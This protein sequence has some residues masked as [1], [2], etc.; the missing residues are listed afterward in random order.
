MCQV[1]RTLDRLSAVIRGPEVPPGA[2][3]LILQRLRAWIGEAQD[4]GELARGVAPNPLQLR[5]APAE[6][7]TPDEVGEGEP[8]TPG[9]TAKAP[10]PLPPPSPVPEESG[11]PEHRAAEGV[12]PV[13]REAEGSPGGRG[14]ASSSKPAKEE[15]KKRKAKRRSPS[16]HRGRRKEA[17][18]SRSGRSRPRS[19]RSRLASPVRPE[20][21]YR[22]DSEE[23]TARR[24]RK[25]RP[26]SPR[27]PSRPPVRRGPAVQRPLGRSD[28]CKEVGTSSWTRSPFSK[29]QRS[30]KAEAA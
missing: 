29:E 17:R 7:G 21:V 24:E 11:V 5:R 9:V 18:R 8:P 10:P 15:K 19:H 22:S 12:E 13:K 6:G 25:S 1:C 14:T 20:G 4:V 30:Y 28:S 16:S 23:R 27:S 3:F 2:E 26:L